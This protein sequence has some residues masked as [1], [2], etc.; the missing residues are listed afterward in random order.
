[1]SLQ[2]CVAQNNLNRLSCIARAGRDGVGAR[3]VS[4]R[5]VQVSSNPVPRPVS[6]DFEQAGEAARC[7]PRVSVAMK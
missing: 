3:K 7:S 6:V 4:S 1:M 2:L 5:A